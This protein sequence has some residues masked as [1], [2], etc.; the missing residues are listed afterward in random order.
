MMGTYIE[1]LNELH[2]GSWN[3]CKSNESFGFIASIKNKFRGQFVSVL[4]S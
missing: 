3:L 1:G 2:G 4:S